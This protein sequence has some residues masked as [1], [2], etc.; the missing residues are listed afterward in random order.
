MGARYIEAMCA[1]FGIKSFRSIVAEGLDL[2]IE[3]A[4]AI[5]ARAAAEARAFAKE[6]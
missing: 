1:F 6:F 4:E 2:G 5:L 3:S